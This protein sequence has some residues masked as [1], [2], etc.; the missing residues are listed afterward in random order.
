MCITTK[1]VTMKNSTLRLKLGIAGISAVSLSIF[2]IPG[3][4]QAI[5]LVKTIHVTSA[6]SSYIQISEIVATQ[7]GTG[8][9]VA[10]TTAGS[11]AT[12]LNNYSGSDSTGFAI[13]GIYP[14]AY[15][16]IYTSAGTIG[17]YLNITLANPTDLSSISIYGRTDYQAGRDIYNLALLDT[18]GNTLFSAKSL[19]AN[20]S[21]YVVTVPLPATAV[22]EPFTV[23]GTLIGGTAAFRMRKKLKAIGS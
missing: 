9:D 1:S 8:K 15:P 12:A 6:I 21:N 3:S 5:S 4:A 19:D 14:S 17:D 22:P 18:T 11:T 16:Q 7:T 10:L 13:D 23:I 2:T 20:N